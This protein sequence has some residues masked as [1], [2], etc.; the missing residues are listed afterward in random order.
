[1]TPVKFGMTPVKFQAAPNGRIASFGPTLASWLVQQSV[2]QGAIMK[3]SRIF[4]VAFLAVAAASKLNAQVVTPCSLAPAIL[5]SA[6]VDA[7]VVLTSA[8]RL[9]SDLRREQNMTDS[10]IA[11]M[12]PVRDRSV[13]AK[14]AGTFE[15]I[16]PPGSSFAVLKIGKVYYVRD[17]DQKRGTGVITDTSYTVL[18]R[19]GAALP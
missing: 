13:C 11:K 16:I 19:L 15:R 3:S 7:F 6:R 12:L 5:D 1:M 14:L 8:S 9:V 4:A 10:T 17:P 18:M 2:D